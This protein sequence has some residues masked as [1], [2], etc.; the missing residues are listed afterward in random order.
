MMTMHVQ[1]KDPM[2]LFAALAFISNRDPFLIPSSSNGAV[3]WGLRSFDGNR[4]FY[5]DYLPPLI[6]EVGGSIFMII[7][8][9]LSSSGYV[10]RLLLKVSVKSHHNYLSRGLTLRRSRKRYE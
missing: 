10:K 1:T 3:L 2:V 4:H 9:V 8:F 6:S 5:E 7:P